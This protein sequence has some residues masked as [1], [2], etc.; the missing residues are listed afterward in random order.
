MKEEE[1]LTKAYEMDIGKISKQIIHCDS[2]LSYFN[3]YIAPLIEDSE[4]CSKLTIKPENIMEISKNPLEKLKVYQFQILLFFLKSNLNK[5]SDPLSEKSYKNIL[6]YC[7]CSLSLS[8]IYG[9][10]GV[11]DFLN[12]IESFARDIYPQTLGILK[13]DIGLV[14]EEKQMPQQVKKRRVRYS[15]RKNTPEKTE[16]VAAFNFRAIR[17][18]YQGGNSPVKLVHIRMKKSSSMDR[19]RSVH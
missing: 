16:E 13:K 7:R 5:E 15:D 19:V 4:E 11:Y 12:T 8:S 10:D 9:N 17:H 1:T 14:V 3:N 18:K 6:N 2:V